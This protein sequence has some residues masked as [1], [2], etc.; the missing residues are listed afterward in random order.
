MIT[1]KIHFAA[2]QQPQIHT[3]TLLLVDIQV[4]VFKHSSSLKQQQQ[5][6]KKNST[7][8]TK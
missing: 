2:F 8:T 6:N 3:E 5:N 7:T 4:A 1:A